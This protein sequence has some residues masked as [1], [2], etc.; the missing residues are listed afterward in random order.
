M[1]RPEGADRLAAIAI[2]AAEQCERLT[3]P[4]IDAPVPL[5]A[6]LAARDPAAPLLFADERGA[7]Q[8]RRSPPAG[9]ART[10][11]CWSAPRAASPTPSARRCC[12]CPAVARVSLGPLILRAETAALYGAGG[13]AAG[14]G[15]A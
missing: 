9:G 5:A 7:R 6:W 15:R 12:G 11:T 2:E 13:L 4:A 10:A 8:A 14:A 3:V 1:V